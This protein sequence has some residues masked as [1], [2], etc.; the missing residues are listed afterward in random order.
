MRVVRKRRALGARR[1][2]TET[3]YAVTN[4]PAEQATAAELAG[5]LRCYWIIENSAHR[6]RDAVFR[7][8]DVKVRTRNAPAV[9]AALRDIVRTALR[10]AGWATPPAPAEPISTQ[11][12]Y[13]PSAASRDQAGASAEHV[14]ALGWRWGFEALVGGLYRFRPGGLRRDAGRVSLALAALMDSRW[15]VGWSPVAWAR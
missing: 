9:L 12:T 15:V 1:W 6:I 14:S 5:W 3:V 2:N 8:D 11:P 7:E 10:K 13:W 4:P